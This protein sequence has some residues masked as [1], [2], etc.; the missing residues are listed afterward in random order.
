MSGETEKKKLLVDLQHQLD[1]LSE[2][3]DKL[4]EDISEHLEEGDQPSLAEVMNLTPG[5]L[6]D[7]IGFVRSSR[8]EKMSI[9]LE[10]ALTKLLDALE[11]S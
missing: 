7:L 1:D 9:H 4:S 6:Q 11:L 10:L 2:Q 3:F 8:E 5:E